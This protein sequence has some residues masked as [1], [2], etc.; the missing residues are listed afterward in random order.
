MLSN[1]RALAATGVEV[2]SSGGKE[3]HMATKL[4]LKPAAA[5]KCPGCGRKKALSV[6]DGD[7]IPMRNLIPETRLIAG[8]LALSNGGHCFYANLDLCVCGKCKA[9]SYLVNLEVVAAPEVSYEWANKYFWLNEEIT[10]AST[11]FTVVA[12]PRTPGIPKSWLLERTETAAGVLDRHYFGPFVASENL[13]GPNGVSCC[14]GGSVWEE[15]AALVGRVWSLV[16]SE[17]HCPANRAR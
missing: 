12:R 9:Q 5:L 4:D 16:T 1:V 2:G 15:A 7:T 14:T 17:S 11:F 6:Q 8:G 10:E 13:E 3:K